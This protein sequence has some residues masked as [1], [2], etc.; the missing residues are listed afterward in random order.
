[1]TARV[2]WIIFLLIHFSSIAQDK[3]AITDSLEAELRKE[4]P[5]SLK[6]LDMCELCARYTFTD[7]DKALNF[8]ARGIALSEKINF[9]KGKA[10]C[11]YESGIVY[12]YQGKYDRAL[13][14]YIASLGFFEKYAQKH[15][16][17]TAAIK[18]VGDNLH[19]MG[20]VYNRQRQPDNALQSYQ[21]ALAIFQS[22]N[23]L[24]GISSCYNNMAAVYDAKGDH[25]KT[26]YYLEEF[27]KISEQLG[28]KHRISTAYNNIGLVYKIEKKYSEALVYLSKGL[29]LREEMQDMK[30]LAYSYN[31][32]GDLYMELGD[33]DKAI[34]LFHRSL[35]HAGRSNSKERVQA[36]YYALS[37]A[38]AKAKKFD[39]A[40]DYQSKLAAIKDS[41]F[42]EETV[43][44]T[45]EM[46][47]RYESDKKQH[48]I[49]LLQKSNELQ[50]AEIAKSD[51]ERKSQQLQKIA[52]AVG[53][54]L[55]LI[56]VVVVLRSYRQKQRDNRN[57]ALQKSIIE[58]KHKEI[59]DS[60]VYAKRIQQAMLT[61]E[62]YIS[63]YAPEHFIY[64]K[65]RDIV[66]GDFYWALY[67]HDKFWMAAC[68]CTGHGVPGAF[69]SLLNISYLNE[70]VL[71]KK[72]SSP[73]KVLEEVR[74]SI[75][76][77]LDAD[78]KHENRDGM[79]CAVFAIDFR[80]MTLE[81]A[82]ANNSLYIYRNGSYIELKADKQPVGLHQEKA[83]PYTLHKLPLQQGDMI[84]AFTDGFADQFGGRDGKKFKSNNFRKLLEAVHD[85]PAREQMSTI[86]QTFDRWKGNL[87][88]VDDVC[89]IGVRI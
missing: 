39:K 47:A 40:Y 6:A 22:I 5:D 76:R 19:N 54:I 1:M 37:L 10:V 89:V 82:C 66:S 17:D 46:T 65:P 31:D 61:T 16:R 32:I 50:A 38:Y 74:A 51:A 78:G 15:P 33:V 72:I 81:A 21:R 73:E 87:E 79:D 68:D 13:E 83:A 8:S 55:I 44:R 4:K 64:F 34:A 84:Y 26:R 60:I 14:C 59:T 12:Y 20:K 25:E 86:A 45:A 2:V 70:T 63:R 30:G 28:D 85:R 27:L 53:F 88:Q 24:T 77:S 48:Q 57:L 62:S 18:Y 29:K 3:K 9:P 11:L 41:L 52:F 35:E 75:M 71:E 43:K 56:I 67:Q 23:S 80:N 42:N 36:A 69:M 49:E 58:V 7:Q